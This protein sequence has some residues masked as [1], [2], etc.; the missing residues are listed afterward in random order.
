MNRDNNHRPEKI[1][2]IDIANYF[3]RLCMADASLT[4]NLTLFEI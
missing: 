2:E 1:D 4:G 3:A